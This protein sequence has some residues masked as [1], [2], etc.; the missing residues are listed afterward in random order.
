MTFT[1]NPTSKATIKR[2]TG[3]TTDEISDMDIEDLQSK[4]EKKIGKPLCYS[5]KRDERLRGRGNVY[6]DLNRFF[7]FNHKKMDDYID[8]IKQL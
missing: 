5:K 7:T 6:F 3:L 4:I 2:I 8:S 1:L